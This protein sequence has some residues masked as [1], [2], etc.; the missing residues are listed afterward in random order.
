MVAYFVKRTD[1]NTDDEA[2]EAAIEMTA[3]TESTEA[4]VVS[5]GTPEN[6]VNAGSVDQVANYL[7]T[8]E[9]TARLQN[10]LELAQ[11]VV[12]SPEYMVGDD[13][14]YLEDY[15]AC[16]TD[17]TGFYSVDYKTYQIAEL[18]VVEMDLES[19]DIAAFLN[20]FADDITVD[21]VYTVYFDIAFVQEDG[22]LT[23]SDCVE[24]FMVEIDVLLYLYPND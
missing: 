15:F 9:S 13:Q 8:S 22:T 3:E 7:V 20:S 14:E 17:G 2:D 23:P 18:L 1:D 24:Y 4:P 6:S 5:S 19:E 12:I 11:S 10:D 16:Y 21:A